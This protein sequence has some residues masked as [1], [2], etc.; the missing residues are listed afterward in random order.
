MQERGERHFLLMRGVLGRG[1]PMG[2]LLA[3]ALEL[4]VGAPFPEAFSTTAFW[5]RLA[6]CVGV[7]SASGCVSAHAQWR[8]L[9]RRFARSG[10]RAEGG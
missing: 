9:E 2:V 1:V 10:E 7:F 8:L 6:L 4:A 5:G 3:V